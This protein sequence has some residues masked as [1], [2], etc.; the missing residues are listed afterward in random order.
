MDYI[1]NNILKIIMIKEN[2]FVAM[3]RGRKIFN[4][5]WSLWG[6]SM[7]HVES[8]F[9]CLLIFDEAQDFH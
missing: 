7:F 2:N 1:G 4:L 9:F 8:S 6:P 3:K 5:L